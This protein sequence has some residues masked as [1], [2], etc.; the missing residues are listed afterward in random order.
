MD[1][2]RPQ[3]AA[4]IVG[5]ACY[6][7]YLRRFEFEQLFCA[8]AAPSAMWTSYTVVTWANVALLVLCALGHAR[9]GRLLGR[10]RCGIAAGLLGML[11]YGCLAVAPF[12]GEAA[13]LTG[14]ILGSLLL[15]MGFCGLTVAW[16]GWLARLAGPNVLRDA[17]LSFA[18]C[19]VLSFSSFLPAPLVVA[20]AVATPGLSGLLWAFADRAP[21]IEQAFSA[22]VASFASEKPRASL[23]A[24]VI[25]LFLIGRITA[26][27]LHFDAGVIQV[28]ERTISVVVS[29][30]IL[31]AIY[32][33]MRRSGN[34]ASMVRRAWL[35]L[36]V[37][38]FAGEI[39]V[40]LF[41]G[42]LQEVGMAVFWATLGCFEVLA[43]AVCA[44]WCAA[45]GHC[46]VP[47]LSIA[48][49]LLRVLPSWVGK[50]AVPAAMN[51][52]GIE[53]M[54]MVGPFVL[55]S[56]LV[57]FSA[58]ILFLNAMVETGGA[59]GRGTLMGEVVP[60]GGMSRAGAAV[61]EASGTS[62]PSAVARLTEAYRLTPRESDVLGLLLQGLS[63]QA[64]A[65]RLDVTLGTV[66]TH[67]K[68]VYR[69][70]DVHSRDELVARAQE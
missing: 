53:P 66:Q 37:T 21:G 38:F 23:L 68:G 4:G 16:M 55:A 13:E 27:L 43:L 57:L 52:A 49:V 70:L 62:R 63:Y 10:R 19:C 31:A 40:V 24:S 50:Y 8:Y 59:A 44:L 47:V 58:T 36:V 18:L 17:L 56:S 25:L 61:L 9:L 11:G 1:G 2:G 46:A 48:T 30:L 12:F 32:V 69:K 35:A 54:S 41:S 28:I 14:L 26:G 20:V 5:L 3:R 6:W 60:Q 65:D 42:V 7:P 29:C 34:L 67:T 33:T 39:V 45:T 51:A 64:I 22:S 15:S